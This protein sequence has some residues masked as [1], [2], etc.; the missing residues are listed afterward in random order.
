MGKI[1]TLFRGR[2]LRI[3]ALEICLFLALAVAVIMVSMT[4][5][6]I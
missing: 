6:Y 4:L 2:V 1:K 5:T 3:T